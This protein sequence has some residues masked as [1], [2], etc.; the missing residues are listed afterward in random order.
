MSLSLTL[1]KIRNRQSGFSLIEFIT[2]IVILSIVSMLGAGFVITSIQSYD[3]AAQRSQL[4]GTGRQALERISRQLRASLPY[5]LR[6][7]NDASGLC[8]EFMPVVAGGNYIGP[9]Y[10]SN[11]SVDQEE[12]PTAANGAVPASAYNVITAP[13]N[14]NMGSPIHLTVG[15]MS[16]TEI[17]TAASPSAREEIGAIGTTAIVAVPLNSAHQ[18]VRESINDRFYILDDPGRFC[19]TG[20]QLFF[21]D[22]YILPTDGLISIANGQPAGSNASLLADNIGDLTGIVPF[23]LSGATQDR[24]AV[25]NITIPFTSADGQETIELK[26][27][28]MIRNVP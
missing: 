24:N 12:L 5:S 18:F 22:N 25:I 23:Q 19:I 13:F 16:A 6:L 10:D 8:V 14:T 17:Y 4:I 2:V 7:S 28:I 21:Y 15:G 11:G 20:N 26:Q 27:A 1:S 3:R 9:D